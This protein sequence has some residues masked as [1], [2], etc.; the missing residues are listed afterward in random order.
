MALANVGGANEHPRKLRRDPLLAL[1]SRASRLVAGGW[2]H[3]ALVAGGTGG[4]WCV[5]RGASLASGVALPADSACRPYRL[6]N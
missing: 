1:A 3:V 6:P 4:E 5:V 2:W